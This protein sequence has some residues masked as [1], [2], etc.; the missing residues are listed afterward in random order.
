MDPYA[1]FHP[2]FIPL[3]KWQAALDVGSAKNRT[4]CTSR[5]RGVLSVLESWSRPP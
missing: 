5:M 2:L 3:C 1:G 4:S